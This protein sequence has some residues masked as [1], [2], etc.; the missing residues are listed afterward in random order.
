MNAQV[1]E[2]PKSWMASAHLPPPGGAPCWILLGEHL[3]PSESGV[4]VHSPQS[5]NVDVYK[6]RGDLLLYYYDDGR[7][8]GWRTTDVASITAADPKSPVLGSG[9][10]YPCGCGGELLRWKGDNSHYRVEGQGGWTIA[11]CFEKDGWT[12]GG[13]GVPVQAPASAQRMGEFEPT[14]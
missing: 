11:F 10:Q 2:E 12:M 6:S 8:P 3:G 7:Y 4:F 1:E 9:F 5:F 13:N 14:L